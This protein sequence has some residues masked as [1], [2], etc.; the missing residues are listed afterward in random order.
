MATDTTT[1][2]VRESPEVEA[3]K[4]NMMKAATML[5]PPQLPGYQVEALT[6]RQKDA[7]GLGTAGIGAYSPYMQA[8]QSGLASGTS[9]LG[10]AANVLR[11]ADTRGQFGAAQEALNQAAVP[12]SQIGQLANVAGAG[13]GYLSQGVGALQGAAQMYNPASAQAFMNPYQQ[14]VIDESI[15]QINRQGAQ[16]NEA[17]D[18]Q[19]I[20]A[21]AFG[22]GR[23]AV[24]KAE[25]QRNLADSKNAA[26]TNA[27]AQGYGGAQQ[28]A[29]QAFQQ[30]QA[31]QLAQGQG[32]Q[33]AAG[34]QAAIA[35][36]QAG[37]LGQQSQLQQQLG[38]GIGS[39]AN[40]QFSVGNQMSQGLGSLG[41]Q[42]GNMGVQQAGL[43]QT[44]QQLGQSDVNFLYNLGSQEQRQN[45]AVL[46]ATR[47]TTM[48]N[49]MQPYQQ[50]AFQSD[51]YKG[52]PSSQMAMTSQNTATP[53]PFQQ[54]AGLGVGLV[55]G[56]GA[57]KSAGII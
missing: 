38:Q 2:I 7:I 48:Q 44:A 31:N 37:I 47:A 11:G 12:A 13:M 53:S 57:A 9:T 24:M 45:Q 32:L 46:D 39:L 34:Q 54:V 15:K 3:Y 43:G 4:L 5:Q 26:I 33:A 29:M 40:Q 1:Q 19:A 42:I 18:T 27:L 16:A 41:S 22:G 14:Q 6:Q 55:S 17:L 25:M 23:D 21:G 36:Q 52:A 56:A 51:I 8:A 10:E 50:L 20:R 49:A 35:G 30:Q 28:Q